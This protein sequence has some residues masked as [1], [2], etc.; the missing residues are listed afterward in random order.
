[1]RIII[2]LALWLCSYGIHSAHAENK[3]IPPEQAFKLTVAETFGG[4]DAYWE[5]APGYYLYKEKIEFS[6]ETPG[7][8]VADIE[9][10]EP[11]VK[12]DPTFGNVPVYHES[13]SLTVPL[14]RQREARKPLELALKIK[15]QGCADIGI[16]Y[17]PI[18]KTLKVNLGADIGESEGTTSTSS[19][20]SQPTPADSV[21]AAPT[22]SP[23]T[24]AETVASSTDPIA[25]IKNAKNALDVER[26]F[27]FELTAIDKHTLQASWKIGKGYHLYKN[28]IKFALDENATPVTL[29]E[30]TYPKG[31]LVDDEF[32]GQI[33]VY[34]R[35]VSIIIPINYQGNTPAV[36]LITHYQGCSNDNGVCYP[37]QTIRSTIDLAALNIP[38]ASPEKP[39]SKLAVPVPSPTAAETEAEEVS[40][41]LE[42]RS[43][44]G[45]LTGFLL[46]GLALV[47]TPCIFPMIPILSGIIAGSGNISSRK[48]FL[49]SLVYILASATAYA[50]IGVMFGFFGQNI[51]ATLQHPAVISAF[52]ALF[53]LLS[54]SMFGFYELQMP[55]SIQNRLSEVSNKQQGGSFLGA[56]MM[57]FLSTLIVGPCTGPVL[58]G[59]LTYIADSHDA[60]LGGTALFTM[61]F[62]M[63]LPLLIV[64]T[65]AGH[66]L[67]RAGAW[68]DTTKAIFGIMMLGMAIYM[69]KRIVPYEVT[70]ALTSILLITSGIYMG[71]LDKLHD[72]VNG[73]NRFW[74]SI[75]LIIFI[76]GLLILFGVASGS[77]YLLQPLKGVFNSP[78]N[79]F[80]TL[81]SSLEFKSV[82]NL[83][84]LEAALNNASSNK[85]VIML[86]FTAEWCIECK[87]LEA[88]VFS[89]PAVIEATTKM[90]M[91]LLKADVTANTES[92]IELQAAFKVIGPPTILFFGIDGLESSEHRITGYMPPERFLAHINSLKKAMQ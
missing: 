4:L 15:Y 33:E 41:L 69:L 40:S 3:L 59:A 34:P 56:A 19:I 42:T 49:L 64:G 6:V 81:P 53:V 78:A 7:I 67:P 61:G 79:N 70:M 5:I 32:F 46:M 48:A 28:K 45:V 90:G 21:I 77:Q 75:G 12:Q 72:E 55:T 23:T 31:E 88:N 9:F 51:Q 71:A 26:A 60:I 37:P 73:W 63:G 43:F 1:M 65:S 86:D 47:F 57:G 14:K 20:P 58:T 17:P 44:L 83:D 16:C 18:N 35:D 36:N 39:V 2:I 85:K 8:Q 10:P 54:L 82:R 91:V 13:F 22:S 66:L 62:A 80:S 24:Q 76:Y 92:D 84:E 38:E 89:S 25:K 68:M 11:K 30:I 52:A 27:P 74:K 29:G 50:F 87:R